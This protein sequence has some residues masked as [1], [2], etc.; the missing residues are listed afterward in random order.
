MSIPQVPNVDAAAWH[1][2]YEFSGRVPFRSLLYM[3]GLGIITALLA[4]VIGY[5][6]GGVSRWLLVQSTHLSTAVAKW[7][8]EW[9]AIGSGVAFAVAVLPIFIIAFAYPSF[10]GVFAAMGVMTGVKAGKCRAPWLASVLGFMAGGGAYIVFIATTLLMKAPLHESSRVLEGFSPFFSYA[11]MM[12]EVCIVTYVATK[13][14]YSAYEVPFCE[15]CGM[16]FDPP[17]NLTV[18]VSS[19]APLIAALAGNTALPLQSVSSIN[20]ASPTR[21]ELSLSRCS[22]G[23]SDHSLTAKIHWVEV[24]KDTP[25]SKSK[26][27]FN[28]TLP[29]SLGAEIE[30]WITT[31]QT[32][33]AAEQVQAASAPLPQ[34]EKKEQVSQIQQQ[35]QKTTQIHS[36]DHSQ[37]AT[38]TA[39]P[40]GPTQATTTEICTRCGGTI[41]TTTRTTFTCPYCGHTQWGMIVGI[42]VTSLLFLGGAFLWGP[43][44]I[45]SFWRAIVMWG[46]GIFGGILFLF[47]IGNVIKG[48]RTPLRPLSEV[49]FT[50]TMSSAPQAVVAQA[51][52]QKVDAPPSVEIKVDKPVE[53]DWMVISSAC[54]KENCEEAARILYTLDKRS[55]QEYSSDKDAYYE[56]CKLIKEV[57]KQLNRKGGEGLMKQVLTQEGSLGGNTHFIEKEWNG[58]GTWAG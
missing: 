7:L 54:R 4:G 3:V 50:Q 6:G 2:P 15:T 20:A 40:S 45:G 35:P 47:V 56:T 24:K 12:I 36:E 48:V 11:L 44:I 26:T 10:I 52:A 21:L 30:Q 28:T 46:G 5:F 32:L 49:T 58:I 8:A 37:V 9:G 25:E 31:A 34:Q 38:Q 55:D 13:T 43:N 51:A 39:L 29:A 19:A 14:A 17:K 42:L 57:G 1:H 22:C 18:P 23:K 27:W 41:D 33:A 53:I 16:W